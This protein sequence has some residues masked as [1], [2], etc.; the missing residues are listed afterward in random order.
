VSSDMCGQS[1]HIGACAR[2]YP[3]TAKVLIETQNPS[4]IVFWIRLVISWLLDSGS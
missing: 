2:T 1:L 4:R 3:V